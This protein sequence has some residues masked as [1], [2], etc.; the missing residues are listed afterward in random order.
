MVEID[1]EDWL[2]EKSEISGFDDLDEDVKEAIYETEL[3]FTGSEGLILYQIN[4][5]YNIIYFCW[6][7]ENELY[8][9]WDDG[10]IVGKYENL[11]EEYL[12]EWAEEFHLDWKFAI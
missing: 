7:G 8:T 12:K 11:L 4:P 10:T 2:I 1:Y 6:V 3:G 9:E 5:K